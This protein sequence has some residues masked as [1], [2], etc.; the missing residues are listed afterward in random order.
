MPYCKADDAQVC[1]ECGVLVADR[2]L[3]EHT[4]FHEVITKVALAELA[5]MAGSDE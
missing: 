3:P 4:H 2:Y 5:R 1:E